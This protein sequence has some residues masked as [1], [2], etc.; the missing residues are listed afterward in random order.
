MDCARKLLATVGVVVVGAFL[1]GVVA[2]LEDPANRR[3][4]ADLLP[5]PVDVVD[6]A[7]DATPWTLDDRILDPLARGVTGLLRKAGIR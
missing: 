1:D 7:T 5:S 3:R 2:W 4:L 6:K